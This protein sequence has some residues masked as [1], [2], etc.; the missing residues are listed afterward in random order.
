MRA[1]R[2]LMPSLQRL[3]LIGFADLARFCAE[4]RTQAMSQ[5]KTKHAE[6]KLLNL[7]AR[8]KILLVRF[9]ALGDVIQTL[10]ILP[11]LRQQYP[12]AYV[13][14][15]IDAELVPAIE[16][17]ELVDRIH[18]CYRKRW[19][20]NIAD[21]S[22]SVQSVREMKK[23]V[24]DVRQEHYD[25]ALDVQG[26]F[27]T[28]LLTF[29]SGAKHRI[30]FAHDREF[31]R[32][33]YQQAYINRKDY[34]D[35][36]VH[37]VDHMAFL[38]KVLGARLDSYAAPLPP[39]PPQIESKISNLIGSAFPNRDPI[40][41]IAPGTQWPSKRWSDN[42]WIELVRLLLQ[43]TSFNLL[44]VGSP[45]DRATV[46]R[47]L[48]AVP[49]STRISDVSGKTNIPELYAIYRKVQ[50]AVA[51]DTAPLHIAGAAGTPF[52]FGLFGPTAMVRTAPIGSPNTKLFST[53][54]QLSCQ[55]CHK[56]VCPLG[57]GECLE[58]ISAESVFNA[59][60]DAVPEKNMA[61]GAC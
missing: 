31:S 10:P 21:V 42:H 14:W 40:I 8:P 36:A 20:K 15:A 46:A 59:I 19:F 60:V 53:E 32:V 35:P 17:H 11:M 30:G 34:F 3:P 43:K 23:F 24:K 27:K 49:A 52:V 18:A 48:D 2:Q 26:L 41:A 12:D 22:A 51:S 5:S 13:G 39:V 57:T 25:V 58:R 9:S 4:K 56:K 1:G 29:V 61:I 16:G 37:H 50:V 54:G 28:A 47:I 7:P 33:F 38:T 55:P 45:G 6:P 44:F